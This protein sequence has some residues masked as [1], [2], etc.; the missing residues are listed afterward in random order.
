MEQNYLTTE[1]YCKNY[2][3]I[4][5]GQKSEPLYRFAFSYFNS[6]C[7]YNNRVSKYSVRTNS[8]D[9]IFAISNE[10]LDAYDEFTHR[11]RWSDLDGTRNLFVCFVVLPDQDWSQIYSEFIKFSP[12]IRLIH[13]FY[14]TKYPFVINR[15]N[16]I[17]VDN[18]PT[19]MFLDLDPDN[20]V[21][22]KNAIKNIVDY[23]THIVNIQLEYIVFKNSNNDGKKH[24][25][26]TNLICNNPGACLSLGKMLK[27]NFNYV[28]TAQYRKGGSLRLLNA[29]KSNKYK[30]LDYVVGSIANEQEPYFIQPYKDSE[31]DRINFVYEK[32]QTSIKID[33]NKYDVSNN[34]LAFIGLEIVSHYKGN[35]YNCK[36]ID[37]SHQCMVCDRVHDKDDSNFVIV[38]QNAFKIGCHRE[39]GNFYIIE[40]DNDIVESGLETDGEIYDEQ[41]EEDATDSR[42]KDKSRL[43]EY[44][45]KIRAPYKSF[46]NQTIYNNPSAQMPDTINGNCLY[47]VSPCKTG[48]TGLIHG[49]IEKLPKDKSIC[50]IT[51]QRLFTTN[52]HNRFV[53]LGFSS[54]LQDNFE[55]VLKDK[56]KSRRVLI[57]INSLQKLTAEYDIII[58]DEI[59]T[60]HSCFA[61]YMIKLGRENKNRL[62]VKNFNRLIK[63]AELCILMDAYPQATTIQLFEKHGKKVHVHMNEYKMHKDD[64][65]II[66]G[67]IAYFIDKMARCIKGKKPIV[68]ASSLR[69]KQKLIMEQLYIV[70]RDVYKFDTSKLKQQFY[71][72]ECDPAIMKKSFDN[73]DTTW[74]ELDILCYTPIITCG[75]SYTGVHFKKV[76][77]LG[78]ADS[79]HISAL[80]SLYRVRDVKTR[81]YYITF[82]KLRASKP[83]YTMKDNYEYFL[84]YNREFINE[85]ENKMLADTLYNETILSSERYFEVSKERYLNNLIGQFKH[86]GSTIKYKYMSN[87][88]DLENSWNPNNRAK[89]TFDTIHKRKKEIKLKN[90]INDFMKPFVNSQP[91]T[92]DDFKLLSE[93]KFS[94]LDNVVD[95]SAK[96]KDILLINTLAKWFPKF[97]E[98]VAESE[99]KDKV[100]MYQKLKKKISTYNKYAVNYNSHK[101][102]SDNDSFEWTLKVEKVGGKKVTDRTPETRFIMK[103]ASEVLKYLSG[104]DGYEPKYNENMYELLHNTEYKDLDIETIQ[105]AFDELFHGFGK[106]DEKFKERFF[107]VFYAN[108]IRK[109]KEYN[110]PYPSKINDWKRMKGALSRVLEQTYN[111]EGINLN[112]WRDTPCISLVHSIELF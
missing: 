60:L 77:Y 87:K 44:M 107:S 42:R 45:E 33:N 100:E 92:L 76:F 43:K 27:Q 89:E 109:Y 94:E 25:L 103:C 69:E 96:Q 46:I 67:E 98:V 48:K 21:I 36:K 4:E 95:K 7:N 37:K 104:Y 111:L 9:V 15:F 71:N 13:P 10:R 57:S 14:D 65:I 50:F 20:V 90:K 66:V 38:C 97:N 30:C 83:M 34:S 39:P 53:D 73:I 52:L 35:I 12:L 112:S 23:L 108:D 29:H 17:F 2:G 88:E 75:T 40:A 47:L 78:N 31:T 81:K 8:G 19:R 61:S 24:V 80:Q 93:E 70:L 6:R 64:T 58:I 5:Y 28:D 82:G 55:Q 56:E 106:G 84:N 22:D 18:R 54:Y 11:I 85:Q 63:S 49:Y 79:G 99:L 74:S 41:L 51:C 16:E 1:I 105:C 72:S 62:S 86:N 91:L 110:V 68:F 101:D 3:N 59:E 26:F 32:L 102:Y